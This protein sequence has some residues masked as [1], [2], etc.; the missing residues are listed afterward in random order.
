MRKIPRITFREDLKQNGFDC[1]NLTDLTSKPI[2]DSHH[3]NLPH[4]INFFAVMV[5]TKGVVNHQVDFKHY[6]LNTNDCLVISKGQVH[7]FDP[8]SVYEGYLLL[9][10]E[11]FILKHLSIS[12][13]FKVSHLL[14]QHFSP[15]RYLLKK[16]LLKLFQNLISE[17]ENHETV[18]RTNI[19]AAHFSIFLLLLSEI[20]HQTIGYKNNDGFD[21]FENFRK[22]VEKN[23]QVTRNAND[24]AQELGI[25][26]KHLNEICKKYTSKTAKEFIDDYTVLEIKRI[27]SSSSMSI[28]EVCFSTGFDEP[29]NF[30]KYFKKKTGMTPA[31]FKSK[32]LL[33][34]DLP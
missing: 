17:I 13:H 15:P 14:N 34:R 16:Q 18:F 19:I 20:N 1:L 30:L 5:I 25:S 31:Q 28:K 29:T 2:P 26:Y 33:V 32:F 21:S 4:R 23:Y 27:L 6:E 8:N 3:P 7:S 9:F 12:T 11:E 10:T 24:Y 22:A